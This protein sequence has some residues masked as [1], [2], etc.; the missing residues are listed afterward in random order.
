MRNH[1]RD[2][3]STESRPK[4]TPFLLGIAQFTPLPPSAR[5]C[6]PLFTF[7]KSVQIKLGRADKWHFRLVKFGYEVILQALKME[8]APATWDF[9]A[10]I[11]FDANAA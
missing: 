8:S 4:N 10:I 7:E 5:N 1:G 3:V 11:R 2:G 6:G 9:H